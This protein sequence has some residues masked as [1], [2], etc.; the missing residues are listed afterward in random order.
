MPR[1]PSRAR[2]LLDNV[3]LCQ[4]TVTG[5]FYQICPDGGKKISGRQLCPIPD[6]QV[7]AWRFHLANVPYFSIIDEKSTDHTKGFNTVEIITQ[8]TLKELEC[9]A[10]HIFGN[11]VKAVVDIDRV[12]VREAIVRV[13]SMRIKP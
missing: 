6:L 7:R 10:E 9:V 4:E 11:M 8:M 5:G 13:V 2:G 12:E 1:A 3:E